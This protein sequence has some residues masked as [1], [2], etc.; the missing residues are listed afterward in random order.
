M[1]Q[2]ISYSL[3]DLCRMAAVT[4]RTV[5]F[6]IQEELLP[7]PSGVR[8]FSR[9]SQEHLT[10]LKIIRCLK[11]SYLPLTE[12]KTLLKDKSL[13]ELDELG[14]QLGLTEESGEEGPQ[15]SASSG[16]LNIIYNTGKIL[17][18]PSE[19]ASN[20]PLELSPAMNLV[21]DMASTPPARRLPG[22]PFRLGLQPPVFFPNEKEADEVLMGENWERITLAPGVELQVQKKVIR[23]QRETLEELVETAR[24]LLDK[25]HPEKQ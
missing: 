18:W 19:R 3:K 25:L 2:P 23:E 24:R 7:P 4:E 21:D 12:I 9:Y 11:A 1:S 6:Y 5:R 16:Q 22:Q 14:R 17:N 8:Q 13:A 20:Q 15:A 10:R